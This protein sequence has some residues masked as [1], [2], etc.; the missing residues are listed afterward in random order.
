MYYHNCLVAESSKAS[1]QSE[2][3]MSWPDLVFERV[4]LIIT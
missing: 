2:S 3:L 1:V 4:V